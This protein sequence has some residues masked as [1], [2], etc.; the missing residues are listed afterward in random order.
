MF[1]KRSAALPEGQEG[2][3]SY[4]GKGKAPA[5]R[6]TPNKTYWP[7]ALLGTF[8]GA[9]YPLYYV[10]NMV[11]QAHPAQ[12]AWTVLVSQ[13]YIYLV[14]AA[15]VVPAFITAKVFELLLGAVFQKH[16]R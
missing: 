14:L 15:A 3:Q 2:I 12:P 7:G 16:D 5:Y 4:T 6:P 8:V 13:G 9:S 10:G 11:L 1:K